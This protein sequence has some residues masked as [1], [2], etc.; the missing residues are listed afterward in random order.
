ME[1]PGQYPVVKVERSPCLAEPIQYAQASGKF[2]G[3]RKQLD[4]LYTPSGWL[5]RGLQACH[6]PNPVLIGSD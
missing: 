4:N 2:S 6:C 5:E 1:N 3:T